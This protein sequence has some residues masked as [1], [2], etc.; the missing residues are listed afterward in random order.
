MRSRFI[1]VVRGGSSDISYARLE[2]ACAQLLRA[3][4]CGYEARVGFSFLQRLLEEVLRRR[5]ESE[6]ISQIAKTPTE[7]DSEESVDLTQLFEEVDDLQI[8]SDWEAIDEFD[9]TDLEI[10]DLDQLDKNDS[11]LVSEDPWIATREKQ[12]PKRDTSRRSKPLISNKSR[13]AWE[14]SINFYQLITISF[15][16]VF[17]MASVVFLLG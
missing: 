5:R 10:T 16:V 6:V 7:K 8:P 3:R 9:F 11:K 17:V 15:L 12:I 14:S 13:R 4:I 1:R 2:I